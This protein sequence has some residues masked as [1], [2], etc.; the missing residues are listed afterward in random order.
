M[1]RSENWMQSGIT[2][3]GRLLFKR[4]CSAIAVDDEYAII[5]FLPHRNIL[6][7]TLTNQLYLFRKTIS[8]YCE[9]FG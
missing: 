4:G 9:K 5:Q 3:Y 1:L 8:V 2:F 7:S 6:D